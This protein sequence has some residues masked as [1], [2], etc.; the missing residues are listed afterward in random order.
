MAKIL[1]MLLKPIPSKEGIGWV[2]N[3]LGQPLDLEEEIFHP[4]WLYLDHGYCYAT[5]QLE[6]ML[7]S[8]SRKG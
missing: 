1:P 5:D 4:H 2:K 6:N 7:Q 8:A 3:E